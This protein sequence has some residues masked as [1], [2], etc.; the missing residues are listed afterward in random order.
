MFLSH[1]Q[2]HNPV[3][4]ATIGRWIKEFLRD[5]GIDTL[6]YK[7]H[8]TRGASGSKAKA[9]G[10]SIEDIMKQGNWSNSTTFEKFYHKPIVDSTHLFQ[11]AVITQLEAEPL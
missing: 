6:T 8:S 1:I 4:K 3:S 7:A 9:V 10:L 11:R 2:P 5:A